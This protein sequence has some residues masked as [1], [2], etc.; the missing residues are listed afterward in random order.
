MIVA[1]IDE[2]ERSFPSLQQPD[3][4]ESQHDVDDIESLLSWVGL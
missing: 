3:L 2:I 4:L 1:E